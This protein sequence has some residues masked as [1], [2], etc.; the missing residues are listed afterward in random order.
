MI[1]RA[2]DYLSYRLSIFGFPGN[3]L[4]RPNLGLLDQRL[5]VEWVRDNIAA[6]GGDPA[7]ITLFGQSAG[8]AAVDYYSYAW[9]EDPIISAFIPMSGTATGFGQLANSSASAFWF[10]ATLK[11]GCGGADDDHAAVFQ[12]MMSKPAADIARNVPA[13]AIDS[14]DNGLPFGPTIDEVIVFSNY[15]TRKPIAAPVLV[16]NTDFETGLFRLLAPKVPEQVWPFINMRAFVC[17]AAERAAYSVLNGNP[18][19]RY[20]FFGVFPNTILTTTPPSGAWHGSDVSN[21]ASL[22][23]T[24][25][26]TVT[27]DA[28][29]VRRSADRC[30]LDYRAVQPNTYGTDFR[31]GS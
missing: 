27:V 13:N 26:L 15:T 20:R 6:F 22:F 14:S 21:A 25:F 7:R 17:P 30:T 11:A 23:S 1:S 18:T 12:C 5:A 8:G 31:Y 3:P 4:S 9:T 19:W 29:K 28:L 24:I 16:G 10:N 2:Y